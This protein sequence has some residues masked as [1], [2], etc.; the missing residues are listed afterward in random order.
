MNAY[1]ERIDA[2]SFHA[3][4]AVE[5]AWSVEEQH[6]AP[7]LGLIAHV[8]EQDHH[9]RR[10]SDL[11][12][13]RI[14]FDILGTMPIDQVDIEVRMLR[15]GRTIEL[16]EAVLSHDGRAAVIARAWLMQVA[17]TAALAGSSLPAMP[18]REQLE[19]WSAGEIWPGQYVRSVDMHRRQVEPGRAW[20]WM[21]PRI[22]LLADE[23]V[24][25]TA[26]LL[27]LVDTANGVTPRLAPSEVA[28]PNVDLTCHL[29]AQPQGEWIGFDTT[30]TVGPAG[31][32]LTDS[33]LHDVT[34]PI[35]TVQQILTVRPL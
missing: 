17:D 31:L 8:I 25:P 10:G 19:P 32:G 1:F 4:P 16:V 20:T 34:G 28:F 23:P 26:R 30:V 3:T 14:S 33:V 12:L 6:I 21:R 35:G 18:D 9:A 5:G 13:G 7:A 11:Q 24:S 2:S 15:P 27:G 22:P 29:V